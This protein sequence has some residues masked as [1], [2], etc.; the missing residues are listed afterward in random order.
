MFESYFPGDNA[1]IK[2]GVP[3]RWQLGVMNFMGSVQ[4]VAVKAKLGNAA[5]ESPNG[6]GGEPAPMPALIE[7]RR[8]LTDN[9]TWVFPFAWVVTEARQDGNAMQLTLDVNGVNVESRV[10]AP[11]GDNFRMIFELWTL[12]PGSD[13]MSFGWVDPSSTERRA[14]WIQVWFNMTLT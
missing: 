1:T 13:D 3:L 5:T 9:E 14:P 6:V 11:F 12:A 7:F 2:P 4:Y 8:V 10:Q